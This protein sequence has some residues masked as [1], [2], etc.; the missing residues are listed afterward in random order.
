MLITDRKRN[1]VVGRTRHVTFDDD[2]PRWQWR[3]KRGGR[4]MLPAAV[5][6]CIGR[7]IDERLEDAPSQRFSAA[8]APT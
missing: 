5:D 4:C 8:A 2:V 3:K 1:S 6:V 7:F